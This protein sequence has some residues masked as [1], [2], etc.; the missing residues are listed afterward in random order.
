MGAD[1]HFRRTR[2]N[3][4]GSTLFATLGATLL[5]G[6]PGTPVPSWGAFELLVRPALWKLAG[7]T[8]LEHPVFQARLTEPL[9]AMA[10]RTCFAPAWLAPSGEGPPAVTPLKERG[11]GGQPSSLLANALIQVPEGKEELAAETLVAA[12]WL[13][14]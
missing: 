11:E 5:F 9:A 4:G 1:I 8:N 6:L 13:G 2:I 10:G 3:L 7:R 12:A 14:G